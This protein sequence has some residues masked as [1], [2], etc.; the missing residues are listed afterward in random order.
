MQKGRLTEII[1]VAAAMVLTACLVFFSVSESTKVT[2]AEVVY[3]TNATDA[4][5]EL[6]SEDGA[7]MQSELFSDESDDT[8]VNETVSSNVATAK[9]QPKTSAAAAAATVKTTSAKPRT[10][11]AKITRAAQ[12]ATT[13]FSGV[14]NINTASVD[15]LT[16]LKGI[17]EVIAQRIVDYRNENGAFQSVED[18]MNV[19]GI[20][21]KK[22]ADIRAQI[23]VK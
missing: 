2:Q 14:L 20:G 21:E 10:T 16:Q 13:R 11:T 8:A 17:G 4:V 9:T 12:T 19:K 5:Q 6:A 18:I 23:K 15:E 1:L 3:K 22:F 7:D